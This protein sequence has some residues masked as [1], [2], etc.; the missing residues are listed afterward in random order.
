MC[1]RDAWRR[2]LEVHRPDIMDEFVRKD[3]EW[4]LRGRD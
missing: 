1:F 3:V 4:G 2:F